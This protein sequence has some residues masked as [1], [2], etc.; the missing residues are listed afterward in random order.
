MMVVWALPQCCVEASKNLRHNPLAHDILEDLG[1]VTFLWHAPVMAVLARLICRRKQTEGFAESRL[2]LTLAAWTL[3]G[4]WC[5]TL[6]ITLT[7]LLFMVDLP[8]LA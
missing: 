3:V 2:R 8:H 7:V 6:Q 1:G 5:A 4:V